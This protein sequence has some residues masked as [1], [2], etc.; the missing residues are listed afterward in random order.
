MHSAALLIREN[1]LVVKFDTVRM[2][3]DVQN[4]YIL[5]IPTPG[6]PCCFSTPNIAGGQ[7]ASR[8]H[9]C[10]ACGMIWSAKGSLLWLTCGPSSK[11]HITEVLKELQYSDSTAGGM[12][13]AAAGSA[14][15]AASPTAHS[16]FVRDLST[17]VDSSCDTSFLG[18]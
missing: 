16:P 14:H 18:K 3:I 6:K 9:C 8:P 2:I 17:R 4:V 10:H 5:S 7:T 15:I 11:L 13:C 12:A 1:A